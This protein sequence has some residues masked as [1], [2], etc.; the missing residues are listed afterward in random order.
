MGRKASFQISSNIEEY[1]A[2]F[3]FTAHLPDELSFKK[4]DRI[5]ITDKNENNRLNWWKGRKVQ[6]DTKIGYLPKMY[7]TKVRNAS[8]QLR[9]LPRVISSGEVSATVLC[10]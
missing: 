1:K 6:G 3:D 9:L 7:V 5:E 10:V 8:M 4:G 2:L